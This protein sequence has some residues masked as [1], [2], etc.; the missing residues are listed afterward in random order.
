MELLLRT[1]WLYPLDLDALS[2]YEGAMYIALGTL[3]HPAFERET[4][5]LAEFSPQTEIEVYEG[6]HH[7]NPPHLADPTR[8]AKSLLRAW[9][10]SAA[11][12]RG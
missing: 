9:S 8:L 10:R 7:L 4:R 3:S 1:P 11:V 12:K 2:R 5:R 6:L